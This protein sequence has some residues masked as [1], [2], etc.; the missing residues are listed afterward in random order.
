MLGPALIHILQN[1][2]RVPL[3]RRTPQQK[4]LLRELELLNAVTSPE[5]GNLGHKVGRPV[6]GELGVVGFEHM[7]RGSSFRNIDNITTVTEP[8]RGSARICPVCGAD[9]P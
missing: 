7:V 3:E 8:E 1:L 5:D 2:K 9:V 6:H 4:A